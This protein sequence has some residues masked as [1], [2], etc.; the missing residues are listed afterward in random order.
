MKREFERKKRH[1]RERLLLF[2][3]A[4]L[5]EQ[6]DL[7]LQLPK[8]FE[9]EPQ[10][11]YRSFSGFADGL[12]IK[13][14]DFDSIK[15]NSLNSLEKFYGE[16]VIRY[17]DL[18]DVVQLGR[19]ATNYVLFQKQNVGEQARSHLQEAKKELIKLMANCQV[20]KEKTE[21]WISIANKNE[22]QVEILERLEAIVSVE[23]GI[24]ENDAGPPLISE[25]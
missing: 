8:L 7:S 10:E 13:V 23:C 12:G 4:S 2:R 14:P 22:N 21:E 3:I 15:T 1:A 18:R 17:P 25:N 6:I 20:S 11:I 9:S 16:L 19:I 24:E 5:G